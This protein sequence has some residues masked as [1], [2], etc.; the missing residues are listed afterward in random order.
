MQERS[1]DGVGGQAAEVNVLDKP[2]AGVPRVDY[3]EW[4][5]ISCEADQQLVGCG[6]SS[7]SWLKRREKR[8][9]NGCDCFPNSKRY[10]PTLPARKSRSPELAGLR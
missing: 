10:Q 3:E 5:S 4:M 1:A 9:K 2:L 8:E 6:C 7:T